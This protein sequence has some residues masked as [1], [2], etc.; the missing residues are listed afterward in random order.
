[1][2][3]TMGASETTQIEP[4]RRTFAGRGPHDDDSRKRV[5]P[6]SSSIG[7]FRSHCS[8]RRKARRG[9]RDLAGGSS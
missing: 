2:K 9:R 5:R 7:E 4:L 8:G 6:T 3:T 1:M